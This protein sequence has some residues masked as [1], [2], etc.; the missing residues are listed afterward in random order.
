MTTITI[1]ASWEKGQPGEEEDS[2]HF[3]LYV[4]KHTHTQTHIPL[5]DY[6]YYYFLKGKV[7]QVRRRIPTISYC[8]FTHT[9]TP[10]HISYLH[11]NYYYLYLKG[12]V[13]QVCPYTRPP[14]S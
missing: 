8:M 7:N 5:Y 1:I 11:Y 10:K 6:Y 9:H 3:L 13:N 4:Y 14:P 12:N 2:H